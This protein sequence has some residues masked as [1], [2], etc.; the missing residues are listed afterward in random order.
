[1]RYR[2]ASIKESIKVTLQTAR[3]VGIDV[4]RYAWPLVLSFEIKA[5]LPFK[6]GELGNLVSCKTDCQ[7]SSFLQNRLP[8]SAPPPLLIVQPVSVFRSR[9]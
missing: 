5:P 7:H 9:C 2:T 8:T 3:F 6:V 4:V 1:M